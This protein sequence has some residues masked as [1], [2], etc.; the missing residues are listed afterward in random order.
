MAVCRG[1]V[2]EG[3]DFS[4]VRGRAVVITGLP[5]P[6]NKDPKIVVKR[7]YLDEACRSEGGKLNGSTWYSQQAS[8]AV[9][10]AIGR[11]IRHVNDYGA[12]ILC[13]HRFSHN[14]QQKVH[15][16]ICW[17]L[18]LFF[19]LFSYYYGARNCSLDAIFMD[20]APNPDSSPVWDCK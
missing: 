11:V 4:D 3:I 2:S 13:D 5:Y 14:R 7:R 15:A 6:P 12:I 1:K 8:R 9:N 20:T 18:C 10:Q 19:F 17:L 16:C